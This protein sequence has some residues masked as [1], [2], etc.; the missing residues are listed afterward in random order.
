MLQ[1]TLH[2]NIGIALILSETTHV[3]CC[4]LPTVVTV[5]SLLASAGAAVPIPL[6]LLDVHEFLH[7]YEVPVIIGSGALLGLSWGLYGAARRTN[8]EKPHCETHEMACPRQKDRTRRVL[9]IAT[10]LFAANVTVYLTLHRGNEGMLHNMTI[11]QRGK[12]QGLCLSR[13]KSAPGAQE[14][15][16]LKTVERI[17]QIPGPGLSGTRPP[18]PE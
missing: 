4:V 13:P 15:G 7:A 14:S 5:L 1:K 8:C 17:D 18:S 16:A 6:F 12:F 9:M 2:R 3:F 11:M 10:I